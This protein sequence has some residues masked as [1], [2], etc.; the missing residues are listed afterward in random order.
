[1][2]F[3]LRRRRAHFYCNYCTNALE[4][5]RIL[6]ARSAALGSGLASSPYSGTILIV[7]DDANYRALVSS[8]L[9]RVG[10]QTT[11]ASSG[12]DALTAA[13]RELP[14]CVLLDVLLPG[15]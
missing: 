9:G 2:I 5:A 14:S 8:I 12:E 13:R 10:Y 11:E 1:M 15:V 7:D 4:S 6:I 3:R